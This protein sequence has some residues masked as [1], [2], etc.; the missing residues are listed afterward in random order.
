MSY[1]IMDNKSIMRTMRFTVGLSNHIII[2]TRICIFSNIYHINY[3]M[4]EIELSLCENDIS[5][6]SSVNNINLKWLNEYATSIFYSN[7]E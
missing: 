5:N 3:V 2:P 7:F 1:W 6:Q 4:M